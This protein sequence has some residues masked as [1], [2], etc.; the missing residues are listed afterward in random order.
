[1]K[2]KRRKRKLKIKKIK[3]KKIKLKGR[4]KNKKYKSQKGR[5]FG[6]ALTKAAKWGLKAGVDYGKQQIANAPKNVLAKAA[7]KLAG[8]VTKGGGFLSDAASAGAEAGV[9]ALL[10]GNP[11]SGL[12]V[13]GLTQAVK[14]GLMPD[15]AK[16]G[17]EKSHTDIRLVRNPKTGRYEKKRLK[18]IFLSPGFSGG[19]TSGYFV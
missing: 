10:G 5:G 19:T 9:T 4:K 16:F 7:G 1:M 3:Y 14:A 18:Q 11:M 8:K 17:H 2:M 6:S 15:R 12:A 13:F